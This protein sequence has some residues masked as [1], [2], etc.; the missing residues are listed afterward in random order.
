MQAVVLRGGRLEV[1]ETPDPVPGPGPG[2]LLVHPEDWYGTVD[3][4]CAGTLDPL[5]CREGHRPR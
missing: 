5:P 4:I 1:R 2:E 3:A